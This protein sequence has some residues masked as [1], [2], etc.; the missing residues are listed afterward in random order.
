M[1]G[2]CNPGFRVAMPFLNY[3]DFATFSG[4]GYLL[5]GGLILVGAGLL[6]ISLIF[7]LR[8]AQS[9][10]FDVRHREKLHEYYRNTFSQLGVILIGIGVSLFIFF[11]QQNYQDNR[12]RENELQQV[13]ARMAVRVARA[14]VAAESLG[15]FDTL[16]DAGGAYI[17]PEDGG[18]NPAVTAEG[19]A[20]AK[21]L[22]EVLIL[23]RDVDIRTFAI[24]EP[25]ADLETS[26]VSNELNSA[27]WF[28][29]VRD[30]SDIKYAAEQLTQDFGDL[31]RVLGAAP[32]ATA[33][34]DPQLG[35]KV[36]QELLDILWDADLLRARARRL[37]ARACWLFSA[38]RGFV[39][40]K[41]DAA[42]EAEPK[43]HQQW[44]EGVKGRLSGLRSGNA[45]CYEL[46][47]A[48]GAEE[49]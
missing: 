36:K 42:I 47:G 10:R 21:Q 14:A 18:A 24:L 45:S 40:L 32:A 12:R 9:V 35:P 33:V 38:G 41:P 27:L 15:G 5:I 34:G 1:P 11:F 2:R 22:D 37:L 49:S 46:L 7:N 28:N 23:E 25:S 44:L 39:G 31:H 26:P 20:L 13:L 19:A 29:I 6:I 4:H 43:S 16:L 8:V 30:E 3:S 48:G 17:R